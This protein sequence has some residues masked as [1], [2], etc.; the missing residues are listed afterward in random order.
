MVSIT[1]LVAGSMVST[2]ALAWSTSSTVA[3]FCTRLE[4]VRSGA[5][6]GVELEHL[7]VGAADHL[8][9]SRSTTQTEASS[10]SHLLRR[11]A[12][13]DDRDGRDDGRDRQH[14][15]SR[16]R[17]AERWAASQL[18]NMGISPRATSTHFSVLG[19]PVFPSRLTVTVMQTVSPASAST[20]EQRRRLDAALAVADLRPGSGRPPRAPGRASGTRRRRRSSVAE[21][22]VTVG[23]PSSP[24]ARSSTTSAVAPSASTSTAAATSTQVMVCMPAAQRARAARARTGSA[25]W[26]RGRVPTG[27]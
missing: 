7:G 24:A 10:S 1:V 23:M 21:M 9:A 8:L 19:S 15:S 2:V 13:R 6:D 14:R 26:P 22:S 20:T 3:P 12:G 18:R 4:L 17:R 11:V 16:W 25:R 5:H 27:A